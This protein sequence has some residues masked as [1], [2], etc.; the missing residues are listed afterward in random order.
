MHLS[1]KGPMARTARDVALALD[2]VVGFDPTDIHSLPP[3]HV[4]SWRSPV[5]EV[6]PPRRVGWS[7][8]L[9]YGRVDRAA[10]AACRAAVDR[11]AAEGTEGAEVDYVFDAD[12]SFV[13]A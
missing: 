3:H 5:D 8:T 1:C 6:L 9:C 7:S 13:W 12:P 10:A 4:P 11:L 2:A